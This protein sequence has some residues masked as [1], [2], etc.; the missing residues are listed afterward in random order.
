[1]RRSFRRF[2]AAAKHPADRRAQFLVLAVGAAKPAT[3]AP[4]PLQQL[5][6]HSL[7]VVAP[8]FCFLRP[9]HPAEPLI[10][11][12]R[13]EVLPRRENLRV[14]HQDASQ[15]HR[16]CM[17]HSAG[18][19]LALRHFTTSNRTW[20]AP[21]FSIDLVLLSSIPQLDHSSSSLK[22]GISREIL[23]QSA[24]RLHDPSDHCSTNWAT[25]AGQRPF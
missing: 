23:S 11:C 22:M 25:S 9:E 15:I 2:S 3:R 13:R 21:G 12:K 16:D 6:L 4:L 17:C 14:G 7:D 10:A 19:R 20:V 1:M 8:R 24:N 18:Y 5:G